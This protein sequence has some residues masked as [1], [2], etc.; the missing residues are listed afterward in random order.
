MRTLLSGD[1]HWTDGSFGRKSAQQRRLTPYAGMVQRGSLVATIQRG[2]ILV[3]NGQWRGDAILAISSQ[4]NKTTY[5]DKGWPCIL[6][7]KLQFSSLVTYW[8]FWYSSSLG[9]VSRNV[10]RF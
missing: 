1:P 7:D 2:R 8:Y 10:G 9:R 3:Q 6:D 5:R 4:H